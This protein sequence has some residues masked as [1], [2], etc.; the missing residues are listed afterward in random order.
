MAPIVPQLWYV[1]CVDENSK[2]TV[3]QL[4]KVKREKAIGFI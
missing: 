1:L 3:K 2:Q 4:R